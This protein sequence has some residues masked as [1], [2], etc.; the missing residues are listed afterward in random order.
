MG[1]G[2]ENQEGLG[3]ER[4]TKWAKEFGFGRKTGVN[5]NGE[6]VGV[7]PTPEWK[8]ETFGESKEWNLGNT[9]HSSI[10]QYGWL[11][12]PIQAVRY[13]ASIAN[14]GILRI[15]QLQKDSKA[16]E[17]HV[18]VDD[19]YMKVVREGM[20]RG[21]RAGTAQALNIQ[22]ITLSAKTGTAQL[23]R[24]NEFMNSWVVGFWPYENPRFAFAV[25]LEK[26]PA[27]TLVGAAP[28][29][30]QFFEWMV[31]EQKEYARGEYPKIVLDEIKE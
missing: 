1:G 16:R 26:A 4:I 13:I 28:A 27:E 21:A 5:L 18:P 31:D 19:I 6:R 23:G 8:K 9:Y 2:F 3:I 12:T 10:G 15:P 17:Y 20:R 25:V 22:G 30:R 11:V 14:G 24:H 7:I 29:M